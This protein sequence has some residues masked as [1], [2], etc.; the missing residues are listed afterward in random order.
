MQIAEQT[1]EW[2]APY[3]PVTA[4]WRV[5]LWKWERKLKRK[6]HKWCLGNAFGA[7]REDLMLPPDNVRLARLHK[8]DETPASLA[9]LDMGLRV[10]LADHCHGCR[11]TKCRLHDV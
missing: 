2:K 8:D 6:G 1:R 5:L 9:D 10:Y 7:L 4:S 11:F 3:P